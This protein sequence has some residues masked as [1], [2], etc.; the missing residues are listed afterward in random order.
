MKI[1]KL[2][3]VAAAAAITFGAA[4]V[5]TGTASATDNI[6]AF[7]EQ[8]RILDTNHLPM[9]GYT[10]SDFGPSSDPIPHNGELFAAN[11]S[12]QTF[13]MAVDPKIQQ[14]LARA[15]SGSGYPVIADSFAGGQIG[16]GATENG[17]LYFDIVGDVPNSVAWNDGIR[18]ILAWIPGEP[19]LGNRP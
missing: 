17:K 16:P 19:I 9:I 14:F 1:T 11:L 5:A 18:D 2:A 4:A 8:E 12:V 7:G 6:K 13:G 3:A 10:V 15:E